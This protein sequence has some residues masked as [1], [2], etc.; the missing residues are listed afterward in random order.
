MILIGNSSNDTLTGG[1]DADTISG[2]EGNDTLIG[3]GGN[4]VLDGGA[5]DDTLD[6]GVGDDSVLGGTGDDEFDSGPGDD[7]YSGGEGF[8]VV[9]YGAAAGPVN[10]NLVTGLATGEGNDVLIG[11]EAVGGSAFADTLTGGAGDEIF[12]GM[13]GNDILDGGGGFDLVYYGDAAGPVSVNLATGA[14]SGADGTD[15]ISHFEGI[16]GSDFSDT[17]VG[18]SVANSLQGNAGNDTLTGGQS[19]DTI[20]GGVGADTAV[21]TGIRANYTLAYDP[22]T[23]AMTATDSVAGRDGRDTLSSVEFLQFADT[24]IAVNAAAVIQLDPAGTYL[25]L[26]PSDHGH[27]PTTVMLADLGLQA[28]DMI[29][30]SRLGT[31]QAGAGF[32]DTSASVLLAAFKSGSGFVAPIVFTGTTSQPQFQTQVATNISQDFAVASGGET[33]V[34]IPVGATMLVFSANDSYFSDNT[35]P[36]GDFQVIIRRADG[37]STFP[38]SDVLFGT[39]ANDT[40]LGGLGPDTLVGGPGND[41]LDG[42]IVTDQVNNSDSN[43]VSYITATVGVNIN[44]SGITGTGSTGTGTAQDGLGGVDTLVNI[45]FV[46][47]SGFNDTIIGSNGRFFEQFDG[48]AGNDTIDGGVIDPITQDNSNRATYQ[49]ASAAVTVNLATGSSSGADGNDRLI[50]INQVRGSSFNDVLLGSDNTALTEWFEGRAGNDTIDGMGGFDGIRYESASAAVNVNLLTG[51]ATDGLGGTDTLLNI[52]GVRGSNFDDILTGGNPANGSG[53]TD[54]LE[55]FMG[56]AGNDT[57]NG[58]TGYD[59]ADYTSSTSGV[60][61]TLGGAGNGTASDGLGGTDTLISI[62][63]VRGSDFNDTLTGSNASYESFEG[64]DGNDTING[65]GGIDRVDYNRTESAVNVN[66]TTDTATDG[67][68]GTD[69]LLNIENVRGSFFSDTIVGSASANR[70]DGGVGD[71]TMTGGDGDDTYIVSSA[72]DVVVELASQGNDTVFASVSTTLSANVE[73]LTLTYGGQAT[74]TLVITGA[75]GSVSFTRVTSASNAIV[76]GWYMVD[77]ANAG[78]VA[79]TALAD[80]TLMVAVEATPPGSIHNGQDGMERGTYTWN[81]STGAFTDAFTVDTNGGWGLAGNNATRLYVNGDALSTNASDGAIF[82]RVASTTNPVVGSWYLANAGQAGGPA[83]LTLL[84]DGTYMFAQDGS[85]VLDPSG[86][87]GM[88]RGTYTWNPLTNAFTFATTVDTNGQWGLSHAGLV[89]SVTIVGASGTGNALNNVLTGNG[90]SNLLQGLGGNDTLTGGAGNDSLIGGVGND[91]MDGGT[92]TD[93]AVFSGNQALYTVTHNSTTGAYTVSSI[94]E[95]VDVLTGV[96]LLQFADSQLVL[97]AQISGT[98]ADG[99]IAGAAI[100][101]DVNGNGVADAG[102]A[103]GIVTDAQ[104]NFAGASS[105]QG[106]I[107]AVGGTNIDTGLHNNLVL[108]APQGA[109]VLNP[110]TTLIQTYARQAGTTVSEAEAAVRAGLGIAADIDLTQYDPLAQATGDATALAVQQV[111]AQVAQLGI[112]AQAGGTNF[113]VI[114]SAITDAIVAGQTIDLTD[115]NDL[116]TV[117]GSVTSSAVLDAAAATN[118][119]IAAADSLQQVSTIQAIANDTTAPTVTTFSPVDEASGIAVGSNIVVTFSEAIALG[120]GHITLKTASGTPVATYDAAHST[121][122]TL[123]G[124]T[125]TINPSADLAYGTSY[126]VEFAAGSIKD[127]AGNSYAGTTSYNFSTVAAGQTLNGTAASDSLTGGDGND[128]LS[129]L[130]GNDS[131]TGAG[132]ND[133]IDGGAAIDVANFT[134][135]RASHTLLKTAGGYSVADHIANRD[136]TDSLV[137]VEFLRF[138]DMNVDLTMGAKALAVSAANLK[139]VE[140]LYVGF[141]NRI[142]EAG[143]LAYWIDQL[144]SG[145]SMRQVADNFYAAGVQYSEL[146]GYSA[147]MSLG[148]Y[149]TKVYAN[150]LGRSGA[151]APAEGEVAYWADWMTQAPDRSRGTIVLEML[152]AVHSQYENDATWGWVASWLNNRAAVSYYYAVEQGL[153]MNVGADNIPWG[154]QIASLITPTDTSAAIELIGV[155]EFSMLG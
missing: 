80:G 22:A 26:A 6:G 66:L 150:V 9:L 76:G 103:T 90:D 144:A 13:G 61:V 53:A 35:D 138:S 151:S 67:Y 25:A 24:T 95:G 15:T 77:S 52:E 30:L 40:L 19:D 124:S 135:T 14:V 121:N 153:S 117:L 111:A 5:G 137:N 126:A 45:S 79:V 63:A 73:N 104:G 10:V 28:G 148:Q 16:I 119:A 101:I 64:R 82:S 127:L 32:T 131:L 114:T 37:L 86:Q 143:G 65:L 31:F 120:T 58:G 44:M 98:V 146:T 56:N 94:A 41:F 33:M 43:F 133:S 108:T 46:Q 36:N 149:I 27:A 87:D 54:G 141:F 57:I 51:V 48:R 142:P 122:L 11:I 84:A 71:D 155:N 154:V 100:Y 1:T 83:V 113:G 38:G 139:T 106:A 49:N 85:S 152:G 70:I 128:T 140:E 147:N 118:T 130:G 59:R 74:D 4:D 21:F 78:L 99:Y 7:T 92:G 23:G 20:E 12:G 145:S 2:L 81:P 129:G 68:G 50:N 109:S 136:G 125:L 116:Q 29:T 123:S 107:L 47:G 75:E 55:W 62:E 72:G 102:E 112:E 110:L 34:K 3:L 39:T 17:L 134:G 115:R 18:N 69:T 8:D 93:T 96:E 91:S 132:G 105:L 60:V 89:S 88:E 97:G 42:G